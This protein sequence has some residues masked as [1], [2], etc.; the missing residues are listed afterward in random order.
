MVA[1]GGD[2]DAVGVFLLWAVVHSNFFICDRAVV[3]YFSD[4]VVI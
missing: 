3:R 4:F 1:V 2:L